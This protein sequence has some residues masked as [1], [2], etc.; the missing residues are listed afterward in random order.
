MK[1]VDS[2][3]QRQKSVEKQE[4][5]NEIAIL[6]QSWSWSTFHSTSLFFET[7]GIINSLQKN[8]KGVDHLNTVKIA[9]IRNSLRSFVIRSFVDFSWRR[10]GMWGILL[11]LSCTQVL[12]YRGDSMLLM[13]F[14][15]YSV[16]TLL[17][18]LKIRHA[19]E[20]QISLNDTKVLSQLCINVDCFC[21]KT[22]KSSWD[23]G[24]RLYEYVYFCLTSFRSSL[25][26]FE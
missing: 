10:E 20:M 13:I 4:Q 16:N 1:T 3:F 19:V 24:I 9:H 25:S 18:F 6:L 11:C 23:A 2:S 14:C 22:Q 7:I 5:S 26:F 17:L 21:G 15:H 8:K 12:G